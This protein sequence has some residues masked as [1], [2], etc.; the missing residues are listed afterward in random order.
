MEGPTTGRVLTREGQRGMVEVDGVQVEVMFD[1]LPHAAPGHSVV[2]QDGCAVALYDV[3]PRASSAA[4]APLTD[5]VAQ[6]AEESAD[7]S[8]AWADGPWP[9]HKVCCEE[10]LG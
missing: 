1:K 10:W 7:E 2:V 5:F 4:L 3:V 8:M 6:A 9:K